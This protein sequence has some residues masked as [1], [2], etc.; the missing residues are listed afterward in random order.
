MSSQRVI[1]LLPATT[2][3]VCALGFEDRLVGRSHEC[4]FPASVKR[5]PALTE[6]R[7]D[8]NATSRN[9][10][11]EV[12]GIV[13]DALSIYRVDADRLRE[14][15]P[16]LILTQSQCEVC[17]VSERDLEDA[18]ADWLGT[19]PAVLSLS[20]ERLADV[21]DD[22]TRVGE[23]MDGRDNAAG[24]AEELRARAARIETSTTDLTDRPRVACIEWI[25]P[26]MAAGNWVPE[27]VEMAGGANLFGEAGEHSP[28]MAMEDLVEADPDVMV[29][30]PCGFD[31]D[32][33]RSEMGALVAHPDWS[34]IK[35]VRDGRVYLAD[36]MQYF[37]RPGP[38]LVES[39]EILA[40]MIH[41]E[42]FDFGHEGSGWR[43][44]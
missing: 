38:R 26:L 25:E 40:E 5:L 32:R 29:V 17:A 4:D 6:P 23:A 10:E 20:P 35:A 1:S 36:G 7:I 33:T 43:R 8:V 12:S 30:M 44:L 27:L 37:S 2:E 19:P 42:G 18:L 13:R 28:W 24:V 21:W 16:D 34:A 41:P 31:I 3:I 22:V 15:S 39:L 11:R 14:L 9:I